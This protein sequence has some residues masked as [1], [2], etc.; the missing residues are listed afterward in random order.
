VRFGTEL[1]LVAIVRTSRVLDSRGDQHSTRCATANDA[2]LRSAWRLLWAVSLMSEFD[3]LQIS[4][5]DDGGSRDASWVLA[6]AGILIALWASGCLD[7]I[8]PPGRVNEAAMG[9]CIRDEAVL[10][11]EPREYAMDR[12]C[13][14]RL[15]SATWP[16]IP[17]PSLVWCRRR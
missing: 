4:Q 12:D 5:W 8:D 14:L 2:E 7:R 9:E 6:V 1:S 17:A 10:R 3:R 16:N 15:V 11:G 13:P